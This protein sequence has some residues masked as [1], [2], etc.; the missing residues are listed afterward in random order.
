[1]NIFKGKKNDKDKNK[2]FDPS[3]YIDINLKT[4]RE[5]EILKKFIV[6]DER[7]KKKAHSIST[8]QIANFNPYLP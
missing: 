1:M 4:D 3:E 2:L 8:N 7:T 6:K 5:D